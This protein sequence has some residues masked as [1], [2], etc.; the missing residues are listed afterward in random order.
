[1]KLYY[2]YYLQSNKYKDNI[3]NTANNVSAR[4][5]YIL[6]DTIYK[7]YQEIE[8]KNVLKMRRIF[9]NKLRAIIK[10]KKAKKT[11]VKRELKQLCSICARYHYLYRAMPVYNYI[12]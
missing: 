1:M 9:I 3:N 5:G 4:R 6:V 10:I 8:E 2:F 11:R 12:I 7:V